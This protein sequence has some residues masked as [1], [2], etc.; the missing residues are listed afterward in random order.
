VLRH[1]LLQ[2][3]GVDIL[4]VRDL[5]AVVRRGDRR[6]HLGMDAGIVVGG[7]PAQVRIVD[8]GHGGPI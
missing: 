4:A 7:E 8:R 5:V 6:E 3:L 2:A 1:H